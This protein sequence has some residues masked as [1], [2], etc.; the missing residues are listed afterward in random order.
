MTVQLCR[1]CNASA[2][3][4]SRYC[5][6]H[7]EYYR[8]YHRN[9]NKRR[10]D[11]DLCT[12][13]GKKAILGRRRCEKCRILCQKA[14]LRFKDKKIKN[15]ICIYCTKKVLQG[16]DRCMEH[17]TRKQLAILDKVKP[18]VIPNPYVFVAIAAGGCN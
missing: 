13:C 6:K 17:L 10:L 15:G 14:A 18:V 11:A 16:F 7:I 3:S 4:G 12:Q 1:S 9:Q 8:N 2:F 5:T